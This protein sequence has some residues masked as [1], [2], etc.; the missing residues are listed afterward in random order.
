MARTAARYC[1][2]VVR[3]LYGLK[4]AGASWWSELAQ[5]LSDLGYESTKADADIW[6]HKAVKP[7]GQEYMR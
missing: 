6:I 3:A 7:N 4:S 5:L 1:L 2:V